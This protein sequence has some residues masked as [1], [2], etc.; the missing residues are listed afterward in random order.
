MPTTQCMTFAEHENIKWFLLLM[1]QFKS[2]PIMLGDF[3]YLMVKQVTQVNLYAMITLHTK[4]ND[5][6]LI[7]VDKKEEQLSFDLG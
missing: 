2:F 7:M 5:F 1:H 6:L 3:F 4:I